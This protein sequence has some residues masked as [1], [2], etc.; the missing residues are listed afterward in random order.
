MYE[1]IVTSLLTK[2][3]SSVYQW[4]P[5]HSTLKNIVQTFMFWFALS[6][7]NELS[8]LKETL[9]LHPVHVSMTFFLQQVTSCARSLLA[10]AC[11]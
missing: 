5:L 10:S 3:E 1:I 11:S 9:K 8:G 2:E 7:S 4:P 6:Q